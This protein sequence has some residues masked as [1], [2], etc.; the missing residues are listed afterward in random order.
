MRT[1]GVECECADLLPES[2]IMNTTK[3][4]RVTNYNYLTNDCFL[5]T[6]VM[7]SHESLIC[8]SCINFGMH[9]LV[10]E[11]FTSHFKLS[12]VL[13]MCVYD[14]PVVDALLLYNFCMT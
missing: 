6:L 11:L 14:I 3:S 4:L 7:V 10:F 8:E 9:M 12:N 2:V 1:H 13:Y 5:F